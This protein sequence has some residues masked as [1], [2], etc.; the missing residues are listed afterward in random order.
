MVHMKKLLILKQMVQDLLHLHDLD[1]PSQMDQAMAMDGI[2][3]LVERATGC[4]DIPLEW[5]ERSDE[6]FIYQINA[7]QNKK[8]KETS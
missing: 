3:N 7:L 8:N 1:S 6:G 2:R 4:S 5:Y